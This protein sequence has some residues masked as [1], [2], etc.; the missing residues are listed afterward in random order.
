MP[1]F[2]AAFPTVEHHP[3][4]MVRTVT[5]TFDV[6]GGVMYDGV[7][8]TG[9]LSY[10]GQTE[11]W[12]IAVGANC[13]KM[14]SVLTCGSADFD[15]YGRLGAAPTTS[16]YNWRGYTSGGEEVTYNNPGAGTSWY[17]TIVALGPTRSLSL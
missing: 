1:V 14:Y 5:Y 16:V 3:T 4:E 6:R 13:V 2:A 10:V 17:E 15:L 8:V 12:N 11:L 9:S 7:P